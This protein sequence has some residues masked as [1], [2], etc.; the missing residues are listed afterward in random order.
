MN[1]R[2]I[3]LGAIESAW[4]AYCDLEEMTEAKFIDLATDLAIERL[5]E[6]GLVGEKL[7]DLHHHHP[8]QFDKDDKPIYF[9]GVLLHEH[10]DEDH[11][12][13]EK[14]SATHQPFGSYIDDGDCM[15]KGSGFECSFPKWIREEQNHE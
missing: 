14:Y 6:S 8:F 7:S 1:E 12:D 4:N 9:D 13:G 11:W 2:A 5:S 15:D 3:V 10:P